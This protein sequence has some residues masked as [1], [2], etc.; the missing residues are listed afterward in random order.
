[1]MG[2]T[3]EP[4]VSHWLELLGTSILAALFLG[5]AALFCKAARVSRA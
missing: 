5:S 1:V 2:P 4:N 3:D